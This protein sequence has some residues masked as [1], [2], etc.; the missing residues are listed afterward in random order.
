MISQFTSD[1][2]KRLKYYV[3]RLIDPRTGQTFYVGKG[4]NNRVFAHTHDALKNYEGE[5][6]FDVE[7]DDNISIKIQQI[8]E[9]KRAGLEVIM[10][11][12]RWGM[13]ENTAFEVESALIDSYA[14]ITND[15]SGHDSDRGVANVETIQRVFELKEFDDTKAE[16]EEYMIIKITQDA[17]NSHSDN[18]YETARRAWRI[19]P[20]NAQK[21]KYILIC[22][23]GEVIAIYKNAHWS[24]SHENRWEFEADEADMQEDAQIIERYHHKRL[25]ERYAKKG[26]SNPI[27]YQS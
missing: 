1:V 7:Q 2:C 26:M 21:H 14:G 15:Q 8:R 13:E 5:N 17:L 25:P 6:Y 16:K 23:Y 9:I 19:N 3:Y 20:Q 11:I 22:L 27:L 12:H 10:V 4:K 24:P 18:V